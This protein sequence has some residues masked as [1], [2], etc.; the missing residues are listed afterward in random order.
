MR[1]GRTRMLLPALAV[2]AVLV[3][4]AGAARAEGPHIDIN[5]ATS[6]DLQQIKGIGAKT[7]AKILAHRDERGGFTSLRQLTE[8]K[9]I[10]AKTLA[11]IACRFYV[12]AEGPLPCGDSSEGKETKPA[13][14]TEGGKVNL[15]LADADGLTRLPGI[16]EKKA[17]AIIA[18]R[19]A[20]GAFD[21]VDELQNIK[22]FGAK[23][24]ERLAPHLVLKVRINEATK[25]ELAALGF[26]NADKILEYRVIVGRFHNRKDL[27]QIPGMD[28]ELLDKVEDL[29]SFE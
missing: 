13:G 24:V 18:Y 6:E 3:A 12:P 10:G 25:G 1:N 15:N 11:K 29:L 14:V 8:V 23:T 7:A 26:R 27:E 5:R 20:H 16:G 2:V 9:G 22:G 19:E 28:K 21:S 4:F 17:A